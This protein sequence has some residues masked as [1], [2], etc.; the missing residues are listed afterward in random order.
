MN[1]MPPV[2]TFI[3]VMRRPVDSHISTVPA[4]TR[5]NI[6]HFSSGEEPSHFHITT[7]ERRK[8]PVIEWGT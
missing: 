8:L 6:S 4:H 5:L 1:T 3:R 2:G 7:A